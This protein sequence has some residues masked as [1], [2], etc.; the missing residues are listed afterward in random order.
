MNDPADKNNFTL[1]IPFIIFCAFLIP[2]IVTALTLLY[3]NI[4]I[5][6]NPINDLQWETLFTG[7]IAIIAAKWTVN[8][9]QEQIIEQR[10]QAE[11]QR[12]QNL[13]AAKI[14]MAGALLEIQEYCKNAF[15]YYM[16]CVFEIELDFRSNISQLNIQKYK[17]KSLPHFN[18]ALFAPI[19]D[20][21]KLTKHIKNREIIYQMFRN[22]QISKSRLNDFPKTVRFE[23]DNYK[24][25]Y[26]IAS[27]LG[28]ITN[29]Y[30]MVQSSVDYFH[31][32]IQA[33]QIEDII[34]IVPDYDRLRKS[35]LGL[36]YEWQQQNKNYGDFP[37]SFKKIVAESFNLENCDSVF[38]NPFVT[39]P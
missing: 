33:F 28:D 27:N 30:C 26:E 13:T 5:T 9:M 32:E 22:I 37:D 12:L 36:T 11:Q 2:I 34:L 1:T 16:R 23:V 25:Y 14:Q 35:F 10:Q 39:K 7:I 6:Q 17:G 21:A 24:K 38:P 15:D 19:I 20:M 18:D 8:K 3:F 29:V 31:N 4:F